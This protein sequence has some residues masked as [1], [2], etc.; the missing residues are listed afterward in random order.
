ML[1][2]STHVEQGA[3]ILHLSGRFDFHVMEHFLSALDNAEVT[4]SPQHV[5]LDLS[6]VTFIDSMAI[7]RVVTIWH[8]LKEKAIRLTLAGQ[9]GHVD[10]ELQNIN[11][12]AMIPTVK[13]VEEALVLPSVDPPP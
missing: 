12:H 4:H 2:I 7:G 5:I 9:R 1:Q 10:T 8:R 6:E 11:L 3:V 13:T